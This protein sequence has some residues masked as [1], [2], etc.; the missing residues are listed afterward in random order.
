[1]NELVSSFTGL[2]VWVDGREVRERPCVCAR[3]S[4]CV[5]ENEQARDSGKLLSESVLAC[6]CVCVCRRIEGA[7]E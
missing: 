6:V 1:M 7:A 3:E 2:C 4:V 5:R